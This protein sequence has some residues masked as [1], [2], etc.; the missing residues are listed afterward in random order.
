MKFFSLLVAALVVS[1]CAS[2]QMD[3]HIKNDD[4]HALDAD[5]LLV[6][7]PP[8]DYLRHLPDL[9]LKLIEVHELDHVGDKIYHL[10]IIDDSHP[11]NSRDKHKERFPDVVVDA[12]HIY[13][14]HAR[15]IDKSYTARKAAN[16][17][18]EKRNCSA[19]IRVGIIDGHIERDHPA[20]KG[21]KFTYKEFFFKGKTNANT[22]HGT[23][24]ASVIT[25]TAPYSGL[26]PGAEIVAANV[27]HKGRGGK[28]IGGTLSIMRALDWMVAQNVP[29]VNM[30]IGGAKNALIQRA[31][32]RASEKGIIIVASAGNDG[33]FSKRVNYPSAYPEVIAI[34]AVDRDNRN[35]RFASAGKYIDF[36]A[37]GVSIWTA[38]PGGG[39]ANSGTSFAAPIFTAY[40]AAAMQH[41]GIKTTKALKEYFK[42]YAIDTVEIGHDKYT[43]WGVVKVAPI[44][45]KE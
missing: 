15:K 30:S 5:E 14:H 6:L 35:A 45:S 25:G 34:T 22:G 31:V 16:W 38:A 36:A 3:E 27:F 7:D 8:E 29:I 44:C 40:A 23:G 19:G 2:H 42:K 43:G 20:F 10:Q 4:G 21:T 12:H 28:P 17:H 24:V 18:T 32:T 11:H 26:L 37:P 33:P 39:K 1:G 13:E 41:L 9:G